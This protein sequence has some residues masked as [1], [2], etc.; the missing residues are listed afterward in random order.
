MDQQAQAQANGA[1]AGQWYQRLKEKTNKQL[2]TMKLK[3]ICKDLGKFAA[4]ATKSIQI[5]C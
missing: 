5:Y 2:N 3:K 1:D 4:F